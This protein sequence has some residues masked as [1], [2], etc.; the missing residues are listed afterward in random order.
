MYESYYGLREKPFALAP[1]PAFLYPSRHHQ[2]A[3][4]MLEYSIMNRAAFSLLT[5]EVGSGKTTLIRQLLGRLK[6]DVRIGLISNTNRHFGKLLQWVCLAYELPYR[7]KDD[8]ELYE[9]FV[10]FLVAEYAAGRRVL[11]IVDEAQNL[12]PTM[13]EELRVLSN[14]NADKHLVLQTILVGQ[15][16]LRETLRRSDLRQFAQRIGTDYHLP[17][18]TMQDARLYVRHRLA[19]AG[20]DPELIEVEAIDLVWSRSGGVP[21]L[22][23][24]LC[25][26]ALVYGYADQRRR[27]DVEL[28]AQVV[29]DRTAGGVFPSLGVADAVTTLDA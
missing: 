9:S 13:L 17:T 3:L 10:D 16:E 27:I 28:M 18:L 4:M 5:G 14:V 6:N 29:T 22:V 7:G 8:A 23:N 2:F 25:D 15:P 26:T 11:L 19:V 20:G 12:D 21:R 1:D 24:Q